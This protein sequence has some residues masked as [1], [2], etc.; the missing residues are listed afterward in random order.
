MA[1][2]LCPFVLPTDGDAVSL[3]PTCS[4][5][6]V[7]L[8]VVFNERDDLRIR[9]RVDYICIGNGNETVSGSFE[10]WLHSLSHCSYPHVQ[11]TY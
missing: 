2:P 6:T 9:V 1:C 4:A 10:Y 5:N 3:V 8:D 7:K 11:L